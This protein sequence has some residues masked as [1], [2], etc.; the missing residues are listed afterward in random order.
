[1]NHDDDFDLPLDVVLMKKNTRLIE[2]LNNKKTV[3][4]ILLALFKEVEKREININ[5]NFYYMPEPID[6]DLMEDVRI[7]L[8]D[9]GLL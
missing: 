2:L 9:E 3:D 1:M 6:R 5:N 7:Y 8:E 4:E